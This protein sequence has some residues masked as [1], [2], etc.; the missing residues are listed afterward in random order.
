MTYK[1]HVNAEFRIRSAF[2][3]KEA[4]VLSGSEVEGEDGQVWVWD[5]VSGEVI[6]KLAVKRVSQHDVKKRVVGSDGKEK[7]KKNVVSCVAWKNEGR[8][9]QWCCAG[10][11]GVVT[12]YGLG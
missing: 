9:D 5:T 8:G 10:T 12:V 7:T 11:D 6:Q 4:W 2:G 3:G 1:G